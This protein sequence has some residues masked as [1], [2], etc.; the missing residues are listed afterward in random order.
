MDPATK[1]IT[2]RSIRTIR[3]ELEFLADS[4]LLTS[5]QLA[6]IIA[7][8]PDPSS[9]SSASI[10]QPPTNLL[11]NT[12]ISEKQPANFYAAAP[13]PAPPPAYG[14]PISVA[15]ASALYAYAPADAGDLALQPTDRI[16][17]MEFMNADWAKGCNERTGQEGIFP[18]SYINIIEEK[19]AGS[20]AT[21]VPPPPTPQQ[22][23][24]YG[25]LPLAVSQSGGGGGGGGQSKFD[26]NGKKFGKKLGNAAIF[27]AGASIGGKI[28]GSIF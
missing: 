26:E 28:V 8:L 5:S 22:A 21:M 13:S 3:T 10:P 17:I 7:L 1:A 9:S 15:T 18:R 27:G 16:Q 12:S 24:N 23:N 25:N 19:S 6:S 2:N 20:L 11:A 4:S 14:G